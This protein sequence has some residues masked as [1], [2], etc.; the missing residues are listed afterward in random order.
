[1]CGYLVDDYL[2]YRALSVDYSQGVGNAEYK[3]DVLMQ[4]P[5]IGDLALLTAKHL[6]PST[7]AH[8]P[9]GLRAMSD[10]S[11]QSVS[12]RT[13]PTVAKLSRF[14]EFTA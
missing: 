1:M 13:S 8:G 3:Y 12:K 6:V 10:L 2:G 5:V 11:P 4:G 9:L 7:S 14:Y